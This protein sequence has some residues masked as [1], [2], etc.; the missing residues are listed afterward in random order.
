MFSTRRVA[1]RLG[2]S[3]GSAHRAAKAFQKALPKT[4]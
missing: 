1:K 4:C 3:I 2:I